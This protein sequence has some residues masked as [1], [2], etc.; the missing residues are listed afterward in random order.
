MNT[1]F[2]IKN[3]A[4]VSHYT[5]VCYYNII[6]PTFLIFSRYSALLGKGAKI[7]KHQLPH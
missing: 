4:K 2:A 1:D 6:A 5:V 3:L 7:Y